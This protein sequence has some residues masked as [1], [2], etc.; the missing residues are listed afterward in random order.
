MK[1]SIVSDRL[2]RKIVSRLIDEVNVLHI[3]KEGRI[4]KKIAILTYK[5]REIIIESSDD[6]VVLFTKKNREYKWH[7]H[8]TW[9]FPT[10]EDAIEGSRDI[11]K[12]DDVW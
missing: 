2:K 10:E 11:I 1:F 7:R 5:D 4:D 8:Y 12:G 6:G 3:P 9:V